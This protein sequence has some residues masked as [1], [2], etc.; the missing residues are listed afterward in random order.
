MPQKLF[1]FFFTDTLN[2]GIKLM[3]IFFLDKLMDSK[4]DCLILVLPH[5]QVKAGYIAFLFI[6]TRTKTS[7]D[8]NIEGGKS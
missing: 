8:M 4:L 2:E 5:T 7:I 6:K 1:R 3:H